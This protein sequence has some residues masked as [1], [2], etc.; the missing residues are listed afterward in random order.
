MQ[1]IR[2]IIAKITTSVVIWSLLR[3][4]T[5]LNVTTI[6]NS[7]NMRTWFLWIRYNISQEIVK[8]VPN[9]R[10]NVLTFW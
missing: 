4:I 5:Q 8:I 1:R 9:K 10:K 2:N 6:W 3:V 7:S